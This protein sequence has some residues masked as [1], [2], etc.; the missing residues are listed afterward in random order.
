MGRLVDECRIAVS[1]ADLITQKTDVSGQPISVRSEGRIPVLAADQAVAIDYDEDRVEIGLAVMILVKDLE[2]TANNLFAM[3]LLRPH[4]HPAVA[5]GARPRSGG[6]QFGRIARVESHSDNAE[7]RLTEVD[8]VLD[9]LTHLGHGPVD[10]VALGATVGRGEGVQGDE[11]ATVLG[12]VGTTG[13]VDEAEPGTKTDPWKNL[14]RLE[15]GEGHDS[16]HEDANDR[17]EDLEDWPDALLRLAAMR[18]RV[19][20]LA[21]VLVTGACLPGAQLQQ[22]PGVIGTYVVNGVDPNGTEYTGRVSIESGSDAGEVTVEWIITGAILHGEGR[23]QGDTLVVTWETVTS[24]RGPSS[25]TAEY[26]ILDNGRLVGTRT[27]D[28]VSRTGTETIFPDP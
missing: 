8:G 22:G 24:P 10:R 1:V 9:A 3:R 16:G 2:A 13:L 17:N 20:A 12:R 19:M 27:V 6:G 7:L 4:P 15:D 18:A 14:D 5:I 25:G 28:G 21:I 23:V 11:T 26:E